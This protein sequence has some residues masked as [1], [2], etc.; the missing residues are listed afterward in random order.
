MNI[1][2]WI[3]FGLLSVSLVFEQLGCCSHTMTN[4]GYS[5]QGQGRA[6]CICFEHIGPE[7]DKS[8]FPL[9]LAPCTLSSEEAIV[10]LSY[11]GKLMPTFV[12][13]TKDDIDQI[14]DLVH[15]VILHSHASVEPA[16]GDFRLTI[17]TRT[18]VVSEVIPR[19][20]M[21]EFL[22]TVPESILKQQP[23]LRTELAEWREL[24][25]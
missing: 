3:T 6:T 1:N 23:Q 13:I 24:I 9:I 22:D 5:S 12:C 17:A 11:R 18:G 10:L 8:L 7:S 20:A 14:I 15:N 21:L 4:A 16:F 25:K 19:R 2:R